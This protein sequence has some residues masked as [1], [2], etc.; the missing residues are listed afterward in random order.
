MKTPKLSTDRARLQARIRR[1]VTIDASNGCWTWQRQLNNWGYPVMSVRT[2][3]FLYPEKLYV[4]RVS[5]TV[6]VRTIR[7]G[8]QIDHICCHPACVNPEHLREVLPSTNCTYREK[9]KRLAWRNQ[10]SEAE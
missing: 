2:G 8:Y 6:F 3:R 7:R 10:L 1:N 5:F 4:H 9:Q